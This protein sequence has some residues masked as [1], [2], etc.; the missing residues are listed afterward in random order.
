MELFIWKYS[1]SSNLN[2]KG[3]RTLERDRL[4]RYLFLLKGGGPTGGGEGCDPRQNGNSL[5][6]VYTCGSGVQVRDRCWGHPVR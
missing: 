6:C 1:D 2:L 3:P 4:P 5:E